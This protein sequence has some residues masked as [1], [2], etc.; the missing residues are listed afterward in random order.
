MPPPEW[1]ESM[2]ETPFNELDSAGIARSL[3]QIADRPGDLADAFF[4]RSEEIEL[5]PE[6]R[7]PGLRV[8]RESGFAVRLA[9]DGKTWLAGR[10]RIDSE[11]FQDALRRVARAMP[12]APY[13]YPDLGDDRWREPPDAPELLEFPTAVARA[14]RAHHVAFPALLTA[15]RH[16]RWVRVIG[17]QL[18]SGTERESYYSFVA[19]MPW[20]RA[21]GLLSELGADTAEEVARQL[22]HLYRARDQPPPAP[23]AGVTVLGPS[24]TAV[25]LHEAVA[26]ALEADTLA[27][28]GHPEAALGLA[29]GSEL[30]DVFD[31]PAAAPEGVR[32][33]ADDEGFPVIRRCLLRA[34]VVEQPLCDTAW[35][36]RSELLTAGAG[37]RGNRHL[38]PGPRS[39]HLELVAG[40]HSRQELLAD[41]DGGL[42]LPEAER[43]RLD[44]ATGEFTL[45]FPYGLR[46]HN[47]LPGQPVGACALRGRVS[48]LLE[49][50]A[51][52]GAERRVAGAGWCA[53]DGVKLP[54]WA[55]CCELRLE[56][57]EIAP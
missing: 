10:D 46:I 35:A 47:R 15:R 3:S 55:T 24:A 1:A 33:K 39:S 44:P 56:G 43:G 29:F 25:L 48:D 4:E 51:G 22:V 11:V 31:D 54:V 6:D 12:R 9:R 32:R 2:S 45:R 8:R 34:G 40:G 28:G 36:R 49:K 18:A 41:A 21:G 52:V 23:W 50:V 38:P 53:K 27:H 14:L 42:Y 16:R 17:T 19:E 13:P 57:A 26:H 5:P 30:L 37:R 7:S 20:G